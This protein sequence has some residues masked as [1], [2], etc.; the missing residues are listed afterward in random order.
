MALEKYKQIGARQAKLQKSEAN[1]SRVQFLLSF[2]DG[3][4]KKIELTR[5][6]YARND[7]LQDLSQR[8]W[9]IGPKSL[10][11]SVSEHLF[12]KHFAFPCEEHNL[13]IE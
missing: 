11:K 6:S 2:G 1:V 12:Q 7:W 13:N 4:H 9:I 5:F 3:F 10:E 8:S